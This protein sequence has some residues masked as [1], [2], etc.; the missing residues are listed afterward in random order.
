MERR[1]ECWTMFQSP[2]TYQ[3]EPM[4]PPT[5]L[6]DANPEQLFGHHSGATR[7]TEK[8]DDGQ[9]QA[10][11][12]RRH[13]VH[14][15]GQEH[16]QSNGESTIGVS[17]HL[18]K[19]EACA[20]LSYVRTIL[21]QITESLKRGQLHDVEKNLSPQTRNKTAKKLQELSSLV[22]QATGGHSFESSP[23][24]KAH[25]EILEQYSAL[26]RESAHLRDELDFSKKERQ[27]LSSE[28]SRL[29]TRMQT[30]ESSITRLQLECS[31]KE[32]AIRN[33]SGNDFSG[34]DRQ[35]PLDAETE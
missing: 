33:L 5:D 3:E 24:Q 6:Q 27:Y 1:S 19:C 22:L 8:R 28:V 17:A 13:K 25:R 9:E 2:M 16:E 14:R 23:L 30:L 26:E 31:Q 35:Q 15:H 10:T 32:E 18:V 4:M 21:D 29:T 12:V 7:D 11:N 34:D 20:E